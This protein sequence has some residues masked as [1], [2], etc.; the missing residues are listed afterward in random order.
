[1]RPADRVAMMGAFAAAASRG[2]IKVAPED[3]GRILP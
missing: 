2:D 1:M 3:Y